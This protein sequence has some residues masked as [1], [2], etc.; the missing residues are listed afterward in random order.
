MKM[1]STEYKGRPKT[2]DPAQEKDKDT[3]PDDTEVSPAK[4]PVTAE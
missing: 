2:W 4:S 3:L 1:G